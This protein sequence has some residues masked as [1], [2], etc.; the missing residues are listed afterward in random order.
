MK[1][2]PKEPKKILDLAAKTKYIKVENEFGSVTLESHNQINIQPKG[3][4]FGAKLK[5]QPNGNI[6]PTLTFDTKK[7][8]SN[9]KKTSPKEAL[10]NAIEEY[11]NGIGEYLNDYKE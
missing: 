7:M 4:S 5:I 10:D 3:T 1:N 11:L 9:I 8:R 2:L 6:I